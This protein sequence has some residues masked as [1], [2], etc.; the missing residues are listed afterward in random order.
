MRCEK[1]GYA[2][3]TAGAAVCT[4]CGAE[5]TVERLPIKRPLGV[6]IWGILLAVVFPLTFLYQIVARPGP[7]SSIGAVI[8][9]TLIFS[10]LSL[11]LVKGRNWAR[12]TVL[13]GIPALLLM[14]LAVS[15]VRKKPGMPELLVS[16]IL[17]A[18]AALTVWYFTRPAVRVFFHSSVL[19]G[20]QHP[21]ADLSTAA[22]FWKRL[23]GFLIDYMIFVPFGAAAYVGSE[24]LFFLG[25][26]PN[27]FV[28]LAWFSVLVLICLLVYKPFMEALYGTTLGKKALGILVV[29]STG[30]H[31][32]V[33]QAYLRFSPFILFIVLQLAILLPIILYPTSKPEPK[34][35]WYL[36]D[37]ALLFI[38]VD[39]FFIPFA[40]RKR[41]IHDMLANSFCVFR[42][43]KH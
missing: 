25:H 35:W 18:L 26:E 16:L 15:F 4:E 8:A 37:A 36:R 1:C 24:F 23:L 11:K 5:F 27:I 19:Q 17:L 43:A 2:E 10:F 3:N 31:I 14:P 42:A 39:C 30:E 7:T 12:I 22:G 20:S 28:Q 33:F 34:W 32:S 9:P 13:I 40:K 41:A 6:T 38:V 21:V 29:E